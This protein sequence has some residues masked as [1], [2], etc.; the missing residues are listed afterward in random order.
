MIKRVLSIF[1]CIMMTACFIIMPVDTSSAASSSKKTIKVA[2][3]NNSIYAYQDKNKVWRGMDVEVMINVAQK[4]GMKI[5]FVDSSMDPDFLG[6][7]DKGKY[8]IVADVV[9]TS[10][11]KNKYLFTDEVIGTTNSTLIVRASDSRWTYGDITQVDKMKIGVLSSYA[12]NNDFRNWCSEHDVSPVIKEYADI[13]AMSKALENGKIDGEVYNA[14]VGTEYSKKFHTVLKLLPESYY[15]AFR[16]SDVKLKNKVDEGLAQILSGNI[17]YLLTLKSKY[18][19]QFNSNILPLSSTEKAYI[20]NNPTINVGVLNGNEPYY[21]KSG[22]GIIPDYYKLIAKYS[23]LKFKFKAYDTQEKMVQAE[24]NGDID[25]IGL[26]IDGIITAYQKGFALTDSFTTVNNV[27]LTKQGKSTSDIKKVAV[28]KSAYHSLSELTS[29]NLKNVKLVNYENAKECFKAIRAGKVDG[30]IAD[31]PS[32]TWLINQNN[33]A[34]YSV[35]P[36]PGVTTDLCSAIKTDNET[37]CTIMNKSISATN[38]SFYGIVT[39]D[40]VP[41]NTWKTTITRIPPLVMVLVVLALL[42][43][44]LGLVWTLIMLRRR[45]KERGE[46]LAAQNEARLQKVQAEESQKSV[47]AKNAFFSNISHDMRT[48]LNAII[49][50]TNMARRPDVTEEKRNEYLEKVADSSALLLELINDTLVL[51]KV[52]SGK[53]NLNLTPESIDTVA[54]EIVT[55]IREIARQKNISVTID[56]SEFRSRTVLMDKLNT[57]KIFLNIINNALKY[58]KSGGHV[59]ITVK[60]TP[61]DSSDPDIVVIVKD[62]GIGISEEFM[63]HLF[64]PFSQEKRHGYESVGT[65]LGLS[66]VKQLVDLMGGTIEVESE[67]NEG[68]TFTVRLH[69]EEVENGKAIESYEDADKVIDLTGKKCM[70]CEDNKLNREIAVELLEIK[71]IIVDA[72]ED[73]QAGIQKFASSSLNEYDFILM[74]VRMP[75]KDGIEATK[76]IRAM[77]RLDAISV[78]ILAMTADAFEDDIRKCISAGMNAHIAKPIDSNKLYETISKY[79]K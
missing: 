30:M 19:T 1:T 46:V 63:P 10:D 25:I 24:K 50:F 71:G 15:F 33:V 51:S 12:N 14:G 70:V 6:N 73:G 22:G 49:G 54:K 45:Q 38:G 27:M 17:D 13:D 20:K 32:V 69:L 57:Q 76:E 7:L 75:N 47:D 65:G 43:L 58:T 5:E 28:K 79:T 29:D 3:L 66:I 55:T 8:D 26:Y 72:V 16:K 18:E 64:D 77:D 68:T 23:G 37:L 74:D 31:L 35:A 48:P 41:E 36:V 34:T 2:V 21:T 4:T 53:L 61:I 40:T 11:R 67:K 44:V 59:W 60:D 9:K 56:T 78:P 52:S 42:I 62:D 39:K